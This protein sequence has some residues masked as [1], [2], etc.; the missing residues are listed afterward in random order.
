MLRHLH[1]WRS[2]TSRNKPLIPTNSPYIL[3][4][5]RVNAMIMNLLDRQCRRGPQK[6]RGREAKRAAPVACL[7]DASDDDPEAK[8]GCRYFPTLLR[9]GGFPRTRTKHWHPELKPWAGDGKEIHPFLASF[10]PFFSSSFFFS[11]SNAVS[12]RGGKR[13]WFI[14][15]MRILHFWCALS[16]SPIQEKKFTD[17][18]GP[19]RCFDQE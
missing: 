15:A 4:R 19:W 11:F 2:G 3:I 7:F 5:P 8:C 1:A 6:A 13:S 14:K 12:Q 9:F 10:R 16:Y 18:K 17:V